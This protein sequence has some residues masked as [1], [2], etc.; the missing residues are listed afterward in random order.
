MFL[1][2]IENSLLPHVSLEYPWV[3]GTTS[4]GHSVQLAWTYMM[5]ILLHVSCI[6]QISKCFMSINLFNSH[7]SIIV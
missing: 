2:S 3:T 5:I 6:K 1:I 4:L 7:N